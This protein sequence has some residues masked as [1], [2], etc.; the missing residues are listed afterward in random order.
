MARKLK[1][2]QVLFIATL[3][4]VVLER[5]HGLQRLGGRGRWS[6]ISQPY[7]FL[8]KQA[9]VGGAGPRAPLASP[10]GS[11]TASTASRHSSGPCLALVALALVAVLF[12]PPVNSA[13]RWFSIAGLGIQ[14]SEL[15][16]LSGDLLHRGA[17]RAADAP[18]QRG[19]LLRCC[20]SASSSARLVGLILLEPDFGTAMSLALIAGGDGVRGRAQLRYVVG[21]AARAL[22]LVA[23]L[24]MSVAVSA[25]AAPDVPRTRGTIRSATASRSSSR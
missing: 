16:K 12:S 2:D 14:P 4:L 19:R 20:P 25:P 6:A 15:A 8:T 11:T 18:D 1:S 9:D 23:A 10:C 3:L 17:A 5:G 7:L 24:V 21:A 13:R 22:P